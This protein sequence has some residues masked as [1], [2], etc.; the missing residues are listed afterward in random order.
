MGWDYWYDDYDYGYADMSVDG[1]SGLF[2]GLFDGIGSLFGS[3]FDDDYSY[4]G[5]DYDYG[6]GYDYDY[7]YGYGWDDD[8]FISVDSSDSL[9]GSDDYALLDS[10]FGLFDGTLSTDGLSGLLGLFGDFDSVLGGLLPDGAYYDD[11]YDYANDLVWGENSDAFL[12][13]DPSGVLDGQAGISV[14]NS[15]LDLLGGSDA[16]L[17]VDGTASDADLSSLLSPLLGLLGGSGDTLSVEGASIDG[18]SLLSAVIGM[19]DES[20]VSGAETSDADISS[21]L[22]PLLG[23]LGSQGTT[24]SVDGNTS[25]ID[26]SSILGLL[27]GSGTTTNTDGIDL[28]SLLGLLGSQGT[29]VS[30]DG[31]DLSSLLGLLG[32][33]GTTLSV[34]GNTSGIDLSSI[35]GLLGGSGTT[36]NTDGIDLSSL[37]GL[38]G[39]QGTTLS[40]DGNTSGIDLS[41]ILGLLG[42]SGTTTSVTGSTAATTSGIDL[43]SILGLLNG[44]G[45]TT[46]VTGSTAAT[47]SGIDLSS[48]LGLLNGSGTTISAD[49]LS[50]IGN[51]LSGLASLYS[52]ISNLGNGD[53][54][55]DDLS[56]L[57]DLTN[58]FPNVGDGTTTDT[59]SLLSSILGLLGGSGTTT[60]VTGSTATTAN[61]IDLSSILGLLNGSGTTTTVTGSTASNTSGIDLSALLGLLNGSG[62]TT[63][64][65][66]STA[67]ATNGVDLS[68]IL[69]L[70]NGSG[71]GTNVS[72]DGSTASTA[73]SGID[74]SSILGLLNGSGTTISSDGLSGIG[75]ALS[76]L[77]SLY[78]G[79]SNLGNGDATWDDLSFLDDLTNVFPNVGDGTTTDTSSLLSS[80]LGLLN[81]SGTTTTVTGSTATTA[82]NGVDLS[83]I[84]GLLG[85][86]GTTTTVTGSTATATNGIDLSSILGLLNGSGLTISTDGNSTT[87]TSSLLSSILGLFGGSGET[88]SVDGGSSDLSS[89]L[90]ILGLFG[91]SGETLSVDGGMSD[92][93]SLQELLDKLTNGNAKL[94]I[95]IS[96][97][98]DEGSSSFQYEGLLSQFIPT[99]T[100]DAGSLVSTTVNVSAPEMKVRGP[101]MTA[102]SSADEADRTASLRRVLSGASVLSWGDEEAAAQTGYW[103]EIAHSNSF[104]DAIRI[105]TT[106]TSFDVDGSAGTF[107]CRAALRNGAFETE[108]A[109]WVSETAAG[110]RQIISNGNGLADVFFASPMEGD[111]WHSCYRATND[112][113]G[114][115]AS[116]TGRNRI[117]D[118]FSGSSSDANILYLTDS[119]NGDALFMDDVYSEFGSDARLSL[120][121]EIR[122]GA[123]DDVVDMTSRRYNAE[124]AGM[125]VR[126]GSGDDVLWGAAGGCML[127]GDDGDD[128][129]SGG[130]GDDIIAGGSG[131]DILNG[132]GGSDLFTFGENWGDDVV[133]QIGGGSVAL[134]FAEDQSRISAVE[135]DGNVIFRDAAGT[136]SV[137]VKN[138]SLAGLTVHFGDD[139]SVCFAG[140][141]AAGAFLGSTAESVFESQTARTHGI[142][143]SL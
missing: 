109:D 93:G 138:A 72:V 58:V 143:A 50:G 32:S 68:A 141:N 124:L 90:S 54:T 31:I 16:I 34:D 39:S 129:I 139:Q 107:A 86:S 111:V 65:T 13:V 41:S 55:W 80:I 89:L 105:S 126:G 128:R 61:G 77:A 29:T 43:S 40:V 67:T 23:L 92:L 133:S 136:S 102:E 88:L 142:L 75:N 100:T 14:L 78:S 38:L 1:Y 108:A 87:D 91:G 135:L 103:V 17:S 10:I 94:K 53:A 97:I 51:A 84:L 27:G 73:T 46:S 18:G 110:P 6:W 118:T 30:T 26:L 60:S 12:S 123:G 59:S 83:A 85:G 19:L 48:I 45:T 79:I 120:I 70:L 28:S 130:S 44:S 47:T 8:E 21:L 33:Q 104:D 9:Y 22:V 35:L 49:G 132:G 11:A 81:G 2:D 137:T 57:D 99:V 125:T 24:L 64:V 25:G 7:D 101:G 131:N 122:S 127:F 4:S 3:L 20:S 117:R 62:T 76:G 116:I 82:T 96:L 42:G 36:T 121:R 69:S 115:K 74:L 140:L 56:F 114:E 66:G 134:W 113:T 37:L 5:Y 106:G 71:T 119:A 112:L 63:T 15:I 98:T 95:E 52:G